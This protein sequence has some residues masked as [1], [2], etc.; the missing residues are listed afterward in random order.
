MSDFENTIMKK[1]LVVAGVLAL[2][3]FAGLFFWVRSVFTEENV[4]LALAAQLSEALGQ[5]VTIGTIGAGLYPRVTVNLGDVSIGN[6]ARI[7][8]R[9]L[10]VGTNLRALISRRIEHADLRLTGARIELPLPPLATTPGGSGS[11]GGSP[12]VPV[13]IVSIDEIVLRDVEVVSGGQTLRA[14]VEL[15]PKGSGVTIRRAE[16]GAGTATV[17]VTG[18]IADLA[19]PSG[20]LSL[21]AG[22]L[23]LDELLVFASAFAGDSKG[24]NGRAGPAAATP[25]NISMSLAVER[26]KIGT[27]RLDRLKGNAR[28]SHDAVMLEPIGFGIFG[29][30]YDGKLTLTT[31]R[32]TGF[33]LSAALSEIDMAAAMKFL[34]SDTLTGRLTGK[35]DLSGTGLDAASVVRSVRGSSRVDISN[36]TVKN[37][38]LVR[39]IVIAGSGRADATPVGSGVSRDERFSRLGA[40]LAIA[41]GLGNTND[42][43]FESNDLLLN[44]AG[45]LHLDGSALNLAGQVQLSDELASRAGRD[46]VRYTQ[47]QG[48][49]TLPVSI[50]GPAENPR[51]AVDVVDVLRRAATNKVKEEATKTLKERLGGLFKR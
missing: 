36:G 23:N 12:S 49:P 34:G 19:G 3:V 41:N 46:L 43:K 26:A 13:E 18:Q 14:D 44:A 39:T 1:T 38:G 10:Q 35:V 28:V 47:E 32:N 37:L 20:A 22:E 30:K 9:R 8:A 45:N 25:M 16:L 27:L 4:R 15:V 21:T 50:T 24:A 33:Q 31:G 7:K 40:T 48:R 51:V 6:P 17:V 11:A 2:A 5:P 29:G 42:L